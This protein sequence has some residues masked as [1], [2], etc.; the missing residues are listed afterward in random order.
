MFIQYHWNRQTVRTQFLSKAKCLQMLRRHLADDKME[1]RPS[2]SFFLERDDMKKL[3]LSK[4]KDCRFYLENLELEFADGEKRR[5]L[6]LQL[7]DG[8]QVKMKDLTDSEAI[9][10]ANNLYE[11]LE[12]RSIK[13]RMI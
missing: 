4:V 1:S 12:L 7:A 10:Y 2:A 3:D 8:R 9:Q 5:V 6:E 13:A 11:D